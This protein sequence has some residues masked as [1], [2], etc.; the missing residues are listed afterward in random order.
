MT[1]W[2]KALRSALYAIEQGHAVFPLSINKTPSVRSP[3]DKGHGC[4]GQCGKPGHGV[5]D[6]TADAAYARH[7][8][9][10]SSR[11]TGYGIAC[12]GRMIGLDLDRKNGVDGVEGVNQLAARP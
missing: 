8:F 11:A 7:L 4:R 9:G 3:H 2:E 10:L 5:H 1:L 6:A 12:G